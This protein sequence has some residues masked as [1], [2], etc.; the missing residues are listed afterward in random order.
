[1]PHGE[2]TDLAAVAK[3][4]CNNTPGTGLCLLISDL[5]DPEWRRGLSI[6]RQRR[7]ELHLLQIC[8][9]DERLDW[10]P[11]EFDLEDSETGAS[12]AVRLDRAAL[13]A[14][15]RR[16]SAFREEAAAFCAANGI[17]CARFDPGEPFDEAVFRVLSQSGIAAWK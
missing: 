7:H 11:G 3:A 15:R 4:F 17:G 14:Q 2:G 5:F 9:D 12:R 16:I 6:L 1:M 13:E 10:E 8:G